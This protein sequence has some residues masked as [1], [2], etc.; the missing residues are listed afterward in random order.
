MYKISF[1]NNITHLS[2]CIYLTLSFANPIRNTRE[3]TIYQHIGNPP[4][5]E[6]TT[7]NTKNKTIN[8]HEAS[9]SK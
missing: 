9:G 8:F 6:I 7:G 3:I 4:V 1:Q 5:T 2:F